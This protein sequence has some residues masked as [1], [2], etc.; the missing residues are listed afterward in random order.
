ML[1]VNHCDRNSSFTGGGEDAPLFTK[2]DAMLGFGH[3]LKLKG[4]KTVNRIIWQA[5]PADMAFLASA[6]RWAAMGLRWLFYV[7][8]Y[9]V[10]C[11]THAWAQTTTDMFLGDAFGLGRG[12]AAG[13]ASNLAPPP[14][15]GERRVIQLPG[16]RVV[17]WRNTD[18]VLPLSLEASGQPALRKISKELAEV[19]QSGVIPNYGK[20]TAQTTTTF[21]FSGPAESCDEFLDLGYRKGVLVS[22]KWTFCAE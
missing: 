22:A 5:A 17:V 13:V 15:A 20:A 1:G 21:R 8:M 10:L 9:A 11:G 14:S 19:P 3:C 7:A 4:I 2:A 12:F 16:M 6:L 18:G